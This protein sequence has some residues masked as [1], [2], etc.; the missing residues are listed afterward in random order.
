MTSKLQITIPK[1]VA[2]R[3]AIAPGD[4]IEWVPA[5]DCIRI[6]PAKAAESP[7]RSPTV[8]LELFDAATK[9][10]RQRQ[11]AVSPA[12]EEAERGWKREE[13]YERGRSR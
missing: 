4:E 1:V 2:E 13:L 6:V 8:R 9:R 10:Q 3:Y 7:L 12:S 5:A 11:A